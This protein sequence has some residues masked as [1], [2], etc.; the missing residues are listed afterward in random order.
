[1]SKNSIEKSSFRRYSPKAR[2]VGPRKNFLDH[3]AKW[4]GSKSRLVRSVIA[5]IIALILSSALVL[6]SYGA[7][8][9]LSSKELAVFLSE[10][11]ET[12]SVILVFLLIIGIGL[13]WVGWRILIGFDRGE[14]VLEPGR[15]AA[16]WVIFGML[17]LLTV[18]IF[19]ILT[20]ADALSA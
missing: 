3:F 16:I 1:M 13:Y 14:T 8:L 17:V 6:A 11:P 18:V 12:L 20:V 9:S 7:L 2:V 15:S 10:H 5:A 19:A 4:L